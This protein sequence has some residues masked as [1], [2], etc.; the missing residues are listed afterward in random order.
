[1]TKPNLT[2]V[3]T[4]PLFRGMT[5]LLLAVL[6][7]NLVSPISSVKAAVS[8]PVFLL[9]WGAYGVANGEFDTPMGIAV[10]TSLER[11]YVVDSFNNRIQ[12]FDTNG[13]YGGQAGTY[14]FGAG[15]FNWPQGITINQSTGQVYLADTIN[16]RVQVFDQNLGNPQ[17]F[18]SYGTAD[19]Q[20]KRPYDVAV[21]SAGNYYVA[22]T[23]NHRIQKFS[24]SD[25]SFIMKFGSYGNGDGQ[26]VRPCGVVVD[27]VGN[28]YVIDEM[29]RVQKFDASGT[30]LSSW[31]SFGQAEGQFNTPRD[32]DFDSAGNIYVAD[33]GNQRIQ[34]FTSAGVFVSQWGGY[35]TANGQFN[36]PWGVVALG[37]DEVFVADTDN[38]RVQR[39]ET[40]QAPTDISLTPATVYENR[41]AG[42]LVGA[43]AAVDANLGDTFTFALVA[44][45]GDT[46][47]AAFALTGPTL[48]TAQ[49][50]DFETRS[51]YTI[52]VRVTDSGGMTYEEA[53]TVTI[54]NDNDAPTV[55]GGPFSVDENSATGTLVGTPV[56]AYDQDATNASFTYAITGGNTSNAFSINASGQIIVNNSDALDY[57]VTQSFSLTVQVTDDGSPTGTPMSG[58]GTVIVNVNPVND[59]PT[60]IGF[61][62]SIP[63]NSDN[64]TAV[65]TAVGSD[66]DGD[67]LTYSITGGNG[68]GGFAINP[69]NGAVTV[70]N[71]AVLDRETTPSFTLT[72]TV[73]DNGTPE[74]SASATATITLTDVNEFNPVMNDEAWNLPENSPVDTV[75]GSMSATDGDTGST[76]T[77]VITAGNGS[78]AFAINSTTGAI[79]VANSSPLD[80]ETTP[81]FVLT[82]EVTDSGSLALTDTATATVTLTNVN[83][84]PSVLAQ[85]MSVPENSAN[86]TSVGTVSVVD[87]DSSAWTFTVTGGTGSSYF[88]V[89]SDTGAV[90]VTD[91]TALNFESSTPSYTLI[92]QATDGGGLSGSGTVTINLTDVNE[93]PSVPAQTLSVP[94]NSGS[95][96]TVGT[97]T[98][99]D[100]DAG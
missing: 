100:P 12:Y 38:N 68:L 59:P 58:T 79:R 53:L 52:R 93:N 56:V 2:Q 36:N 91:G 67:T 77:Y 5:I 82:V 66:P 6:F 44:G 78:G 80:M 39:F 18:G 7:V 96:V 69:N 85:S 17:A 10:N 92:V 35:G 73:T 34:K 48:V 15:E 14:G 60:V 72:V 70:A 86:G 23:F 50:F 76:F 83:E 87:V 3:R 41:S 45:G 16:S 29:H 37:S 95:G 9:K 30:Y 88:A 55:S 84:A 64:G 46:D 65:G 19:G 1:M 98:A 28:I 94:E 81:T 99:S 33:T 27:S 32:I 90:T 22:D 71:S 61:S 63:E 42:T 62:T 31:G 54:V 43:L 74:L 89:A 51:L 21:D 75:V 97:V 25:N 47:N 13:V 8:P 49:T 57:E 4:A 24:G 26:F 40:N 11:V 20:F